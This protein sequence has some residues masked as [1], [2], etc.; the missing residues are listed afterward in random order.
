MAEW[1]ATLDRPFNRDFAYRDDDGRNRE[2]AADR[3]VVRGGSWY[4]ASIAILSLPYRET[5]QPEVSAPYLGFSRKH[6]IFLWLP[7]PLRS[8]VTT[9]PCTSVKRKWRP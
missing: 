5:F 9:S 3:R 4:S 7:Q 8:F 2:D 1:T 6:A